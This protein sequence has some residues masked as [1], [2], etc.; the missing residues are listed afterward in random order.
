[1]GG[2]QEWRN[3][4]DYVTIL[5]VCLCVSDENDKCEFIFVCFPR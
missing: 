1:M 3:L 5:C 4:P 2:A